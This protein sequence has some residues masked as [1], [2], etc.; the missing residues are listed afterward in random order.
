MRH[1]SAPS[2]VKG[3]RLNPS[4]SLPPP[5]LHPLDAWARNAFKP[6]AKYQRRKPEW[7]MNLAYLAIAA[8]DEEEALAHYER[9]LA[10]LPGYGPVLEA[11][12]RVIEALTARSS[13]SPSWQ[14]RLAAARRELESCR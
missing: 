7:E 6:L 11:R 1:T 9:A 13:F 8:G 2:R 5:E 3:G 12:V 14:R 10:K 4:A